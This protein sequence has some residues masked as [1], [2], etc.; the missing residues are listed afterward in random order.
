MPFS[1]IKW[2]ACC[3]ALS[4]SIPSTR[5]ADPAPAPIKAL[6][7]AGGGY[8]DY[9]TLTPHLT[10]KLCELANV[11]FV[12]KDNFEPLHDP[13]FADGFDAIVYDWCFDDAPDDVLENA[14]KTT[15][16]GK[17]TVMLHC[18]VHA[19]RRSAKISEW[20]ACIGM[21]SKVH[22]RFEPFTVIKLDPKNPIT[23]SFPEK[24]ETPGDELYQTISIPPE[25]QQ[26]LKVKSP[27]DGREHIVCWT[28][29]YHRGPVFS[30]TLGH[31]MKT[32]AS[33]D[34]L[35]LL[36]NGLLWSCGKLGPDGKPAAGYAG[37][38]SK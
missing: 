33:P 17:P 5:A 18:A 3:A 28:S 16:A 9:A 24:W 11:T 27:Q 23:L 29:R 12:V 30:T 34:Y 25:S 14:L 2:G 37:P 13:K 19:F 35:R 7:F 36:A 31:D 32:A 4:L 21:R 26:L 15:A 20:E 8:H 10:S 22:D 38:Q 6:F 1:L